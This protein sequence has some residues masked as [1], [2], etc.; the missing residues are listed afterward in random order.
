M[1]S[2]E[3]Q[4]M[5][6][7]IKNEAGNIFLHNALKKMDDKSLESFSKSLKELNK[8]LDYWSFQNDILFVLISC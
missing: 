1:L 4:K 3:G 2:K 7:D 5:I 8:N 6:D